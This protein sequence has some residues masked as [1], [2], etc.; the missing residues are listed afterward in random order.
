MFPNFLKFNVRFCVQYKYS[1]I[2]LVAVIVG[3]FTKLFSGEVNSWVH[4]RGL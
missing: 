2:D 4:I 3:L 1:Y